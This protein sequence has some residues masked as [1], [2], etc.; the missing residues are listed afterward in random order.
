MNFVKFPHIDQFRQVL[1][2]LLYYKEHDVDFPYVVEFTGTVKLHGTNAGV[3]LDRDGV[4]TTQA[5]RGTITVDKDNAG[6]ASFISEPTVTNFLTTKLHSILERNPDAQGV[7]LFGEF[8]GKSIQKGVAICQLDKFFAPFA[9]ALVFKNDNDNDSAEDKFVKQFLSVDFLKDFENR[10]LRIFPVTMAQMFSIEVDLTDNVQVANVVEQMIGITNKVEEECPF[11]KLFDISGIGEGVVYH[12]NYKNK[13]F[14]FKVKGEKHSV[15]KV[16]KLAS[17]NPEEVKAIND[18]IDYA[19]T[20]NRLQQG[21]EVVATDNNV[22]QNDLEFN[23]I[24]GFVKFMVADIMREEADTIKANNLPEKD[25]IS[26]IKAKSSKF[27][28]DFMQ[29]KP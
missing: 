18:F 26:Q 17:V 5:R 13:H 2:E 16:K 20:E 29:N 23:H 19:V 21:L 4:L 3:V 6:F 10:D 1:K 15:S 7:A 9:I 8:A 28:R 14:I 11:A 12:T 25:V 24:S 27:Y 22:E